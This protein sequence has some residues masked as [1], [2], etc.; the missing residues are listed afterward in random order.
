MWF[1]SPQDGSDS[2]MLKPENHWFKEM[3][4]EVQTSVA[5]KNLTWGE[6]KYIFI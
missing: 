3:V 2:Y 4:E 6:M 5:R 1:T